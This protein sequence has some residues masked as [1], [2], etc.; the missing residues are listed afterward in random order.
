[1]MRHRVLLNDV[2]GIPKS[3]IPALFPG[4]NQIHATRQQDLD[5]GERVIQRVFYTGEMNEQS[6]VE[7]T[8]EG[9]L[10]A[11]ADCMCVCE[12]GLYVK[13]SIASMKDTTWPLTPA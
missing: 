11:K 1:M 5:Q 4:V 13:A 9:G 12:S 7:C 6:S 10:Y 3:G 8:F 2:T